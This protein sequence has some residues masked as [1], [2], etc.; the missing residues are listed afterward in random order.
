MLFLVLF[1]L[2]EEG[3]WLLILQTK[4]PAYLTDCCFGNQPASHRSHVT[5]YPGNCNHGDSTDSASSLSD[6]TNNISPCKSES[7]SPSKHSTPSSLSPV[8]HSRHL[9]IRTCHGRS[10][11]AW[12]LTPPSCFTAGNGQA[13]EVGISDLENLL[14]EHPSM[15]VYKRSGSE[16]EESN[17][18]EMSSNELVVKS[19]R[20]QAMNRQSTKRTHAVSARAELLAQVSQVKHAQKVQQKHATKRNNKRNLSRSNKVALCDKHAT[21]KNRVRNPSNQMNGRIPQRKQ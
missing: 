17:T 16:G 4:S 3:K 21:R 18:S 5:C 6:S 10:N 1:F 7:S 8:S 14:I 19:K 9:F 2:N 20:S 15:S 13:P 12:I 11:E